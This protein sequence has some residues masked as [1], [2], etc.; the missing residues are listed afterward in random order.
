MK[1]NKCHTTFSI[2]FLLVFLWLGIVLAVIVH[3]ER[4]S[5]NYSPFVLPPLPVTVPRLRSFRSC[6]DLMYQEITF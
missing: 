6:G 3:R 2:G 5:P 4:D 1:W